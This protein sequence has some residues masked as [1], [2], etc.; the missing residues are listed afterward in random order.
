M[1][2]YVKYTAYLVCLYLQRNIVALC[3][4]LCS[5]SFLCTRVAQKVMQQFFLI[6]NLFY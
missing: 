1:F 4:K 2:I 3:D 6:H 5:N